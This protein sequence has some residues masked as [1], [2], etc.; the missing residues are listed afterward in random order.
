[1]DDLVTSGII[2]LLVFYAGIVLVVYGILRL[3]ALVVQAVLAGN[4][5]LFG[6]LVACITGAVLVYIAVGVWLRTAGTI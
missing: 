2:A 1:M 5:L 6:E 3:L 4:Y